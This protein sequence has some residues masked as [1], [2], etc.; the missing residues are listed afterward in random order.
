VLAERFIAELRDHS[1][2][3]FS[4]V[5]CS[6]LTPFMNA[7]TAADGVAYVGAANEGDA[8]AVAAGTQLGGSPG[9]AMFQ[10]SGLGNAV[11]PLTSLTR[12]FRLPVLIITTWRG[13]PD[14]KPD[15]VQHEF[16]GSITPQLLE[17]M[18]IPWEPFPASEAEIPEVVDRATAYMQ[19][20][21]QPYAL[22]LSEGTVPK[23]PVV[24]SQADAHGAGTITGHAGVPLAADNALQAVQSVTSGDVVIAT[25]G[26]TGRGLYAL[27]DRPNQ[28][29]MVGSMGCAPSL[30]LGLALARPD[31]RVVV[32]DG[33]GAA[34]M[35]LGA[36]AT[37][38]R[39]LPPNL[40]HVLLDN[41]IHESMGGQPT[42]GSHVDFP[43]VA[44]ASGY[45]VVQL[46]ESPAELAAAVQSGGRGLKFVYVRTAPRPPEKLPRPS[47]G[48]AEVAARLRSWMPS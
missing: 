5:P 35:R 43:A 33:D 15:E 10:N 18:D 16:M 44:Q 19:E 3:V 21:G 28:L 12:P 22:I 11:N 45:P 2:R 20:T 38:G 23:S 47:I 31:L 25:T 39:E 34:L 40:V 8:V 6:Y 29:Y 7:V 13:Q 42:V 41:G 32:L 36:Y 37:I 1:F 46:V 26:Y 24:S 4:G 9:V 27:E 48:P 30:G 17:L 14:G